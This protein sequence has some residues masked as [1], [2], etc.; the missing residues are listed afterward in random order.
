MA[1]VLT[2]N[3]TRHLVMSK[4]KQGPSV[5]SPYPKRLN[6]PIVWSEQTLPCWIHGHNRPDLSDG[7]SA[8]RSDNWTPS[9][10][11]DIRCTTYTQTI[12]FGRTR[13]ITGQMIRRLIDTR[14]GVNRQT[15]AIGKDFPISCHLHCKSFR[16]LC[17]GMQDN[18][19][20]I[21]YGQSINLSRCR[22]PLKGEQ[23]F[24]FIS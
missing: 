14:I 2:N 11:A 1:D 22:I 20:P 16:W 13:P 17:R 23:R 3:I 19:N 5:V 15:V 24:V 6:C 9:V 8:L 10:Y 18:R 4:S 7:F 12:S 21:S